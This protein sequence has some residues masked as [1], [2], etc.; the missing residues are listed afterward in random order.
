LRLVKKRKIIHSHFYFNFAAINKE[1]MNTLELK[2]SFHTL[3]E[4]I[5][6]KN[7]LQRLYSQFKAEIS[8]EEGNL[9]KKLSAIE[10]YDLLESYE[11]SKKAENLTSYEEMKQKHQKWL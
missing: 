2:E 9:W 5:E 7:L 3:I 11:E 1:K 6:D 4:S 8:Q 10:Q